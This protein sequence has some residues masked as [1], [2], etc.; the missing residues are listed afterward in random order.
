[1][2]LL[3]AFLSSTFGVLATI[4]VVGPLNFKQL[5]M[6]IVV[7]ASK[8]L[9]LYLKQHPVIDDGNRPPADTEEKK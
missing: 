1:M 5:L 7:G 6:L 8:D 3:V 9:G 2:G 4:G